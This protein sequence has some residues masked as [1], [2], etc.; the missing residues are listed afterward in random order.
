MWKSPFVSR[1]E[2]DKLQT[3]L[4][5]VKSFHNETLKNAER[6]IK[7]V[8]TLQQKNNLLEQLLPYIPTQGKYVTIR[9]LFEKIFDA[10]S[11][12]EEDMYT[13]D[14]QTTA[15]ITKVNKIVKQL[16]DI[17]DDEHKN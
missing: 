16:K 17:K 15:D 1:A 13:L 12:L 6:L 2:Y 8:E 4:M 9:D 7:E 14:S 11:S 3:E 5:I 10:I